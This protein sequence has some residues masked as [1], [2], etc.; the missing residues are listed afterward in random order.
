MST[1]PVMHIASS[2]MRAQSARIRIIA[3]NVANANSTAKTPEEDPYRR[4]VAVFETELDRATGLEGVRMAKAVEDRS[5]FNLRYQPGHPNADGRGY[6][7]YPNVS[8]LIEMTDM[9]AAQR[10]YQA[11][12]SVFETQRALISRTL[13]MLRG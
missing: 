2:G 12:I 3:E 7:K 6:V 9:R 8:T 5:D 11:N 4:K 13:Q 10:S 1:D